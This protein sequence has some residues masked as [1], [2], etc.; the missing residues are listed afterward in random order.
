MTL[1][2]IVF[3]YTFDLIKGLN[4]FSFGEIYSYYLQIPTKICR[5]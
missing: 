4:L 5:K 3:D 1:I 2:N